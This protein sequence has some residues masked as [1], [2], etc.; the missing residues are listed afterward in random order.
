MALYEEALNRF[1]NLYELA[2][3]S[4]LREPTAVTLATC[5]NNG[6]PSARTVLLKEVNQ[7]GFVFYTNRLS[8]KGQQ[9]AENP[10]AALCFFGSRCGS[11]Y[12]SK[13]PWTIWSRRRPMPTGS[14][15]HA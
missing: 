13:G 10:K 5:G 3:N 11:R 4:D 6:Q 7:G 12:W 8:R 2:C 9:L 14:P 15:G 1:R